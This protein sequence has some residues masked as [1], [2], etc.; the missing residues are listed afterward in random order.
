[1]EIYWSPV[2]KLKKIP[3][4]TVEPTTLTVRRAMRINTCEMAPNMP[5]P[6]ITPPKHMA[7]MISQISGQHTS[8]ASRGHQIIQ[9]FIAG[10]DRRMRGDGHNDGFQRQHSCESIGSHNLFQDFGLCHSHG[11]GRHQGRSEQRDNGWQATG[12]QQS[13]DQR[14]EQQ[15]GRNVIGILQGLLNGQGAGF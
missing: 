6:Y 13:G 8:H 11:D 1:M 9:Q 10:I 3:E 15:P 7:Q 2:A 5:L 4:H 14:N 12:D